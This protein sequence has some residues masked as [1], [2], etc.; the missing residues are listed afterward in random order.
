MHLFFFPVCASDPFGTLDPFG[1]GTFSSGEGFADFSQMS[2]VKVTRK[3]TVLLK[4]YLQI[5][6]LT[7]T[8]QLTTHFC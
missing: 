4:M 8:F 3:A 7:V 1:N 2:K 5:L 6:F